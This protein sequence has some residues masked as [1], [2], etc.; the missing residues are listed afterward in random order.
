[1]SVTAAETFFV[2]RQPRARWLRSEERKGVCARLSPHSC[3]QAAL[4]SCLLWVLFAV[5]VRTR[6][7]QAVTQR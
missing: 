7:S 2:P 6:A 5:T 1:M 4:S 3:W